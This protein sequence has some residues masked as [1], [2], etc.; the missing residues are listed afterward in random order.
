M[1][2]PGPVIELFIV[3]LFGFVEAAVE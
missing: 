2:R 1:A 3:F